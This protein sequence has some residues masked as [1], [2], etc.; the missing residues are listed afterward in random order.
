MDGYV[1]TEE[2]I[3]KQQHEIEKIE[4]AEYLDLFVGSYQGHNGLYQG[5]CSSQ[6]LG[7]RQSEHALR[8]APRISPRRE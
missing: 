6:T 4:A 3:N 7:E 8:R 2:W 1:N 5:Q